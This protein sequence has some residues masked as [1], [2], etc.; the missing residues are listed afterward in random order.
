MWSPEQTARNLFHDPA[1]AEQMLA[2]PLSE[3]Q[4]FA[5]MKNRLTMAKLAWQPRLYNPH[6]YKWLHRIGVPTL[7]LFG[8]DDKVIPPGYG[9]AF[10]DL[11]PGSRLEI[12]ANCGHL[13]QVEHMDQW[14]ARITGF[15]AEVAP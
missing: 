6:L 14:T 15:I 10:R 5:Q 1:L 3:E 7:I 4:Q 8:D 13:P 9:P 2:L 12:I 11:I